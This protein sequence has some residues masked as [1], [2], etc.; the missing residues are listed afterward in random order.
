MHSARAARTDTASSER[1]T[2][3]QHPA[4]PPT[5]SAAP[6]DLRALLQSEHLTPAD[7]RAV[8]KPLF[9]R[10][11][12]VEEGTAEYSYVRNTLVELN[13]PLVRYAARRYFSRPEPS[14]DVIQ[15]GIIG[16]IKAINR[17]DPERGVE[18]PTF[19]LPTIFGEI[20]RHFRDGS[21]AVRVPRALQ[22]RRLLLA[23]ATST[24]EQRLGRR[25]TTP[26]LA[27]HLDLTPDEVAEGLRA[28]NGYTA[29]SLDAPGEHGR[30][31]DTLA[32]H[33]GREDP[34]LEKVENLVALQP[35]LDELPEQDRR[36]LSMHYGQEMTQAEIGAE[37]GISQTH[38]SRVLTR[39][40]NRLRR[41]L[42]VP[43]R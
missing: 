16:L 33:L 24:L 34:D 37:L 22:E 27:D 21:W 1:D 12:E 17:F 20:K 43:E 19:A 35:A 41:R 30:T 38:V 28:G 42:N 5:P 39:I 23:S 15:V 36:I 7:A 31:D 14:E 29:T 18:F 26:E 3:G 13:L 32:D 11:N 9:V 6:A 10:L 25:P 40:L 4:P 8:S 2:P